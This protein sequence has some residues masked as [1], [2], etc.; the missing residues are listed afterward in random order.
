MRKY[1]IMG[2][3]GCGKGTQANMLKEDFHL[4]HISI[5]DIFRWNIQN[6]TRL[7]SRVQRIVTAGGL[8]PDDIVLQI[9][10]QRL[11]EHDWNYGFIL[12]GFPR[13]A[14]QAEFFLEGYDIDAVILVDVP[15]EVVIK[16]ISSRRL[17]KNCGRD[18]NLLF[19]PPAKP[20][21]CD[22]CGGPLAARPDDMPEAIRARLKDYHTQTE[23]VLD[24]FRKKDKDLVVVVDGTKT[25]KEVQQEIRQKLGLHG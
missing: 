18:F 10:K 1:V 23:P 3:Q 20:D 7:A 8:V 15:D 6:R 13:N 2:V 19:N 14:V 11:E 5:G 9:V 21:V 25:P 12:D 4:V 24:M 17:C 16:R 22:N